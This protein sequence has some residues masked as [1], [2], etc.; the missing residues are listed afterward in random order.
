MTGFELW[1]S[2]IGSDRSTNWATATSH[3]I[4]ECELYRDLIIL[5]SLLTKGFKT[6]LIAYIFLAMYCLLITYLQRRKSTL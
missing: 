5:T 4:H 1:T 2:G 3:I 6:F